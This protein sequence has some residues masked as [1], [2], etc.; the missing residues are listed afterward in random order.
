ML[1]PFDTG[2]HNQCITNVCVIFNCN[3][4]A[5]I[6]CPPNPFIYFDAENFTIEMRIH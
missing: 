2:V 1:G 6:K 4:G 3:A 5:D